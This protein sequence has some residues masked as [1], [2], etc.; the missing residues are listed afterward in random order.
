MQS[1]MKNVLARKLWNAGRLTDEDLKKLDEVI[2]ALFE[3]DAREDLIQQ[4]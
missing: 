1:P 3:L 2:A 4:G